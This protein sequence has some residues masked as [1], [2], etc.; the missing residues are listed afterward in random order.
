MACI[1]LDDQRNHYEQLGVPSTV[2][3]VSLRKSFRA[4]SKA[5]HPD[6]TVLPAEEAALKFHKICEAYDCLSDPEKRKAY[7]A[8]LALKATVT[9]LHSNSLGIE[10]SQAKQQTLIEDVR[11][12]LSGGELFSL[13]LLG[14]ALLF[15]L[16]L[17]VGFAW[18]RGVDLQV[19]PSWLQ[20]E[21]TN[22]NAVADVSLALK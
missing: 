15:C 9:N 7:D 6:T 13:F 17:G 2:D 22:T 20:V 19:N 16:G 1:R 3:Q 14:L 8:R 10:Y 21:Q 11:R 5:L 18:V 4:L 12:P